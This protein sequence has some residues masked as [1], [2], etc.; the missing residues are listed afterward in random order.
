MITKQ[1]EIMQLAPTAQSPIKTL[2]AQHL[3]VL[4]RLCIHR[5]NRCYLRFSHR[6]KTHPSCS[7]TRR[8]LKSL[9]PSC[10]LTKKSVTKQ[11]SRTLQIATR[12]RRTDRAACKLPPVSMITIMRTILF[13]TARATMMLKIRAASWLFRVS[14]R[15]QL[16]TQ[17]QILRLWSRS[18]K[19]RPDSRSLKGRWASK[20]WTSRQVVKL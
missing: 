4:A 7:N 18:Q 13:S 9:R 20:L 19:A 8:H 2:K 10:C 17:Y 5:V 3:W 12:P 11:R 1:Y 16:R 15:R 14:R 6:I